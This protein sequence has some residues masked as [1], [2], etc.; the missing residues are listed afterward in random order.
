MDPIREKHPLVGV[1]KMFS[2]LTEGREAVNIATDE[3]P[4]GTVIDTCLAGDT[5]V[6]E[7]G[8]KRP[9]IE[10]KWVIVEQYPDEE[11]AITGHKKWIGLMTEYPD[12]PL[13]DIDMWNIES[14]KREK[15]ASP[16]TNI[17]S[18]DGQIQDISK[19]WKIDGEINGLFC[20][21]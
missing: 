15:D 4:T 2:A 3:L 16:E 10:G 21:S 7:T 13:K 1:L 20:D 9:S 17:E 18:I 8:I 14:L 11:L 19:R 6:H 12:F 5:Q